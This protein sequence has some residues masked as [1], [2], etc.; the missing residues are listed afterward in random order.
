LPSEP[1]SSAERC[2]RSRRH[3]ARGSRHRG[4][5]R[6]ARPGARDLERSPLPRGHGPGP[7]IPSGV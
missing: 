6:G 7:A 4:D 5:C 1:A 2:V 3:L